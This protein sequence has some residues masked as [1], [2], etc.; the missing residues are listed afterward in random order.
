MTYKHFLVKTEDHVTQVSFNRPEKANSLTQEAWGEMQAIFEFLDEDDATRVIVLTGE[1]K[2]FCGGID[3]SLLMNMQHVQSLNCEGKKREKL[4]RFI[5]GLQE[6]IT[7]IEKCRKPV[8]AAIH[9]ACIGAGVDIIGACDMRYSAGDAF[10]TIKEV[11]MGLVADIGTLQ[12][13]PKIIPYGVVAELAYTGRKVYGPEAAGFGLVNQSY[14]DREEMMEQ[15]WGIARTIAAKSPLVVR[16]IKQNLLYTRD[17]SVTE[18]LEYVANWN[19]AMM[20]SNDL[21][22]SFQAFMQKRQPAYSD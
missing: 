19:A 17:H 18:S 15:V 9:G 3:L 5:L 2:T 14:A 6:N 10:F 13:L 11:D 21:M 20:L 7:S 1:G 16:G 4:R 12:R 22:E 8:L